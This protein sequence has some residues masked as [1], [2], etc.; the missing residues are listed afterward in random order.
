MSG[1][2]TKSPN[3]ERVATGADLLVHEAL[4]PQLVKE[5]SAGAREAGNERMHKVLED[6][7]DYHASPV[8]AAEIA[9]DAQVGHL[10]YY[11]IVPPLLLAPMETIFV[12][13]VDEIYE[14]PVTLGRDGTMVI[15]ES[16]SDTIEV[17]TKL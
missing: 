13:G 12:E 11:H 15:M 17:D 8:E 7:L 16:D 10:L 14:G 6:V 5:L 3:L 9:R 1:D 2:T 4:A